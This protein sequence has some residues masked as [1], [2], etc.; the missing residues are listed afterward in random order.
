MAGSFFID[1]TFQSPERYDLSKFFDYSSGDNHDI[2]TSF[3]LLELKKLSESGNYFVQ[4]EEGRPDLVSFRIY[5]S[6]QYW[7]IILEYNELLS[8]QDIKNGT[9]IKYPSVQDIED[10]YFRLK[11]LES[12]Q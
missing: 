6:V 12:T 1:L 7:W 9:T 2:L 10:L 5:G 4:S 8:Y 11:S 3:F